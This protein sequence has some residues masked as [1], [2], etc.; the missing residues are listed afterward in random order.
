MKMLALGFL[1]VTAVSL[2]GTNASLAVPANGSL[3]AASLADINPVDQVVFCYNKN[4]GAFAH[5]GHCRVVCSHYGPGG[6]C[7]KVTW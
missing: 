7:R 4:T 6:Y 5:W 2:V 1:A 3:I